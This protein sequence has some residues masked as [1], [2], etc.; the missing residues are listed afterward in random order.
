MTKKR[1]VLK[2][3]EAEKKLGKERMQKYKKHIK[4]LFTVNLK[5]ILL[6]QW[7]HDCARKFPTNFFYLLFIDEQD[8]FCRKI[9]FFVDNFLITVR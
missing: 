1:C 6:E 2:K 9:L 5:I 8:I 4:N 3:N 7:R